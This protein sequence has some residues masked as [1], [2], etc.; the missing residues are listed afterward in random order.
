MSSC[1]DEQTV[2]RC[3]EKTYSVNPGYHFNS[4]VKM[5]VAIPRSQVLETLLEESR[6]HILQEIDALKVS[7]SIGGDILRS[8]AIRSRSTGDVSDT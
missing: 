6:L 4:A 3:E 2:N 8:S 1:C 5:A 7:N